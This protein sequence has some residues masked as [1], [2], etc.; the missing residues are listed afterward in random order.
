MWSPS[1]LLRAT[2]TKLICVLSGHYPQR[3]RSNK[4]LVCLDHTF[5][6]VLTSS[7]PVSV[8][9]SILL[10]THLEFFGWS[11]ALRVGRG[12]LVVPKR[13]DYNGFSV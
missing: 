1:C 5:R 8:T 3:T 13:S 11:L 10:Q 4:R 6:Q 7:I 2:S 12:G 9:P